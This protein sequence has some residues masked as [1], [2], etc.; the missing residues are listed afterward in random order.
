VER[1]TLSLAAAVSIVTTLSLTACSP[2]TPLVPDTLVSSI[3]DDGRMRTYDLA[4]Q[5]TRLVVELVERQTYSDLE[6]VALELSARLHRLSTGRASPMADRST[7]QTLRQFD[8]QAQSTS[9]EDNRAALS[10]S[11]SRALIAFDEGD[12]DTAKNHALEVVALSRWLA[13][14]Q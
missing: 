3:D 8:A 2:A 12:F 13:S 7:A 11:A 1:F 10:D 9:L 14:Q 5:N 6:D 4:W